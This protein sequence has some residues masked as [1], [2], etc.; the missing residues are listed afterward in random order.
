MNNDK[1]IFQSVKQAYYQLPS[2]SRFKPL[3]D[4]SKTVCI[5]T[6]S[7]KEEDY[8][9]DAFMAILT[10]KIEIEKQS[11]ATNNYLKRNYY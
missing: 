5:Y 2:P 9:W 10:N 1:G 3:L 4:N 6:A 7:R 11:Q 8:Y